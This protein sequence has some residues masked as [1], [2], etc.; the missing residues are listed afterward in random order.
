MGSRTTILHLNDNDTFT[1]QHKIPMTGCI[2]WEDV[3]NALEEVNYIGIYNMELNLK[4][5]GEE[6]LIEHAAFAI[7]VMKNMLE[8]LP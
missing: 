8:K 4:H 3:F 2:D 7:R 5:F 1:D 6:L